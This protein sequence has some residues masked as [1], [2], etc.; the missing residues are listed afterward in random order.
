[1]AYDDSFGRDG[2]GRWRKGFCP[3][4][5]GRPRKQPDIS[6]SDVGWFKQQVVEVTING[7][8]RRLTRHEVLL[9][10]MY[11]QAIKGK[12]MAVARKL[13]DRFEEVDM[14]WAQAGADL[15]QMRERFL[16]GYYERG[17]FD[18]KEAKEILELTEMLTYG[19]KPKPPRKPRIKKPSGPATWRKGPKPQSLLDLEKAEAEAEAAEQAAW[20]ARL[21]RPWDPDE[22]ADD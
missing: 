8:K 11:E 3:N 17:K 12:N 22:P 10:A 6:D 18:E 7:E 19:R 15:K 21:K 2:R 1:M 9:H 14:T 16:E 5:K 13:F 4:P 20:E